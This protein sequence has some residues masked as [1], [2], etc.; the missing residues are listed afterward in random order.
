MNPR[1]TR[2]ALVTGL[3]SVVMLAIE[4]KRLQAATSLI[5]GLR[6]LRPALREI[7]LYEAWVQMNSGDM[8][9]ASQTLRLLAA[10]RPGFLTGRAF[11]A[12]CLLNLNNAEWEAV[13]REVVYEGTDDEALSIVIP[14]FEKR[15][16]RVPPAGPPKAAASTQGEASEVHLCNYA[17]RA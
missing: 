3:M 13:A 14:L 2:N 5:A 8:L 16:L 15:G 9:G 7:D 6:V 10:A 1:L 11:L 4:T 12:V 17:I